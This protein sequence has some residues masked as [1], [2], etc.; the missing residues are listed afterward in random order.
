MEATT[1]EYTHLE[2]DKSFEED[3]EALNK[4][5]K[6]SWELVSTV[7]IPGTGLIAYLKR[8]KVWTP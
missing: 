8:P 2:L 4:L 1:W 6:E 7:F 5:G 3:S